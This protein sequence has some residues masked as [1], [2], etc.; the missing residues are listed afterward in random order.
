MTTSLKYYFLKLLWFTIPNALFV[1]FDV[2][3]SFE[4]SW[5]RAL[6]AGLFT[7][8]VF[9]Y[10]LFRMQRTGLEELGIN[11]PTITDLSVLQ[12]KEIESEIAI[13]LLFQKLIQVYDKIK[14]DSKQSSILIK[15]KLSDYSFGEK[16]RLT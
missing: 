5:Y 15:K 10:F 13:D 3:G 16:S 1:G 8:L 2:F 11:S 7:G 4:F 6:F 12:T 9:P 14:L